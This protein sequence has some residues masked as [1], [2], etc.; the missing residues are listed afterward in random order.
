MHP[1][2][3][4]EQRTLRQAISFVG[5]G[6]HSGR[7]TRL[8]LRPNQDSSGILFQR[9]DVENGRGLITARWYNIS[10]TR[11][12]TTISNEYGVSVATIEHLMA[13]LAGCGV[14]N[15]LIDIDGPEVP[16]MDG[17]AE[18]FATAIEKYGTL[19]LKVPRNAIWIQQPI[20][21]RDGDK[22]ALLLPARKPRIT[23]SIDFPGTLI[24]HYYG[25]KSGHALNKR[26]LDKLFESH[27]AWSYIT[28]GDYE[29]M[30]GVSIQDGRLK[31]SATEDGA[32]DPDLRGG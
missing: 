8:T 20:E 19:S 7:M 5:V 16:I 11:L 26:L 32:T 17:S 21:V 4:I 2:H 29:R 6:L 13:A 18:P 24:G 23:L 10:D 28:L 15:A 9:S 14:D 22:H 30:M 1:A 25:H 12:S 3:K 27:A 31:T